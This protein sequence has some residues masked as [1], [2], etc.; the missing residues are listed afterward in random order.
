MKVPVFDYMIWLS[1]V[2]VYNLIQI[3]DLDYD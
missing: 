1:T 3:L 2:S